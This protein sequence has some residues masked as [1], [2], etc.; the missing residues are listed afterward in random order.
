MKVVGLTGGLASGKSLVAGIFRELGAQII[1]ADH[2]ARAIVEPGRP[3]YDEILEAFGRTMLGPDG[4]LDRKRL[5]DLIFRDPAARA[6]LNAITHKYIRGEIQREIARLRESG[7]RGVMVVD[8]PLLLDQAAKTAYDLDAVVVVFVDPDTQLARLMARD[9]LPREQA[10]GRIMA[11]RPLAEKLPEADWVVDNS[12]TA[13]ETRRQV[14]ALWDQ[15]RA[16]NPQE[17]S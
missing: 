6:K 9:G 4:A 7:R 10:I 16:N 3:A 8:I 13:E 2:V 15:L 17:R 1:D 5:G 14:E 11:Q 12:G